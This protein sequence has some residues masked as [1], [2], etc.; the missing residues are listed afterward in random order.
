MSATK[1]RKVSTMLRDRL[2]VEDPQLAYEIVQ[3]VLTPEDTTQR[4]P[5]L[6]G[7]PAVKLAKSITRASIPEIMVDEIIKALGDKPDEQRARSCYAA[8]VKRTGKP[9]AW[10]WLD[11]YAGT[12]QRPAAVGSSPTSVVE[13][14]E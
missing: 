14:R 6:W 8:M 5:Y 10:W 11:D 12:N 7:H 13:W 1:T 9:S 3:A 4:G 2:G